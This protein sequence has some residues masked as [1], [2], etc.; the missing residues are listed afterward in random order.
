MKNDLPS[1]WHNGERTLQERAGSAARMEAAGRHIIR[2]FMPEQHSTFYAQLP[3]MLLAAVDPAGDPWVTLVEAEHGVARALDA[4]H[5][6]LHA[7]PKE[8]DPAREGIVDGAAVG[9][10]GIEL[11]T[12][13]RNRVNGTLAQVGPGGFTLQVGESFGNCPQYIQLRQ[14]AFVRDPA[15]A[16]AGAIESLAGLDDDAR[17]MIAAADTF[18]V[19]SY[20]DI[21]GARRVDVSHRGGKAGFVRVHEGGALLSWPDFAGNRFFNTLGNLALDSRAGLVFADFGTGD[22]L[23]VAGRA[24]VVW[25]GAEVASFQGAQRIVR[26]QVDRWLLR[27]GAFP[28][29]GALRELSPT[30]GKTGAWPAA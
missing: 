1:V 27:R 16:Y 2:P 29:R 25:S 30:L 11:P 15:R 7:L 12:R 24:E 28:L 17:T 19:G 20:A 21:D 5:L 18:F 9:M 14:P 23:H 3:F 6:R 10:L 13:R 22:L 26:L 8:G 4:T